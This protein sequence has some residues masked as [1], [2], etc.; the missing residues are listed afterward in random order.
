MMSARPVTVAEVADRLRAAGIEVDM[1]GDPSIAV[2]GLMHD[3]REVAPGQ[4]F[5]CLRGHSFD[6]HDYATQT[7]ENGVTAL[8]VDHE[9][10]GVGEAVQLVVDDTRMAVGPASAI[11]WGDPAQHVTMIGITGTNGK[12]TTAQIVAALLDAADR[13]TGIIGT[14]HGPRTTPEAP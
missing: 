3:S 12:T 13:P 1:V 11:A 8:L 10:A 9:L 2:Q 14:L 5:A 4:L 7:V 6:G